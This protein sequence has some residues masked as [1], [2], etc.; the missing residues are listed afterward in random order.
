MVQCLN[1]S[2]VPA[3]REKHGE[4]L[5]RE[6]VQCWE[7]Y[8]LMIKWYHKLFICLDRDYVKFHQLLSTEEVG[9]RHFRTTVFDVV[10]EEVAST[11]MAL[12][13]SE[14]EGDVVDHAL[15]HACVGVYEAMGLGSLEE[16]PRLERIRAYMAKAQT[17]SATEAAALLSV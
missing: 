6:F 8:S 5:L 12:I 4:I 13:D 3:L 15:L 9:L 11:V 10:R 2:V 16:A 1:R 17:C 14:R 7:K